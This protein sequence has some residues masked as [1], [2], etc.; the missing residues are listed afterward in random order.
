MNTNEQAVFHVV[1]CA[2]IFFIGYTM[3]QKHA[4]IS[5]PAAPAD[6]FA[7]FTTYNGFPPA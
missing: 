2:A 3:G 1:V 5:K 7:W 4:A 6:P